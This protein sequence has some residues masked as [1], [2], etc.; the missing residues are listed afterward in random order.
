MHTCGPSR[1]TTRA[2]PT[3]TEPAGNLCVED[4]CTRSASQPARCM[5]AHMQLLWFHGIYLQTRFHPSAPPRL[6]LSACHLVGQ[7]ASAHWPVN[8]ISARP[9]YKLSNESNSTPLLD[10][11]PALQGSN[12]TRL[13][14]TGTP[15]CALHHSP[16][17]YRIVLTS[18]ES[19][20]SQTSTAILPSK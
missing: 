16:P 18:L 14:D 4:A 7:P 13:A 6:R 10:P 15:C 9:H 12:L 2:E 1:S 20:A 11:R 5:K 8:H 19:S 3:C 17:S